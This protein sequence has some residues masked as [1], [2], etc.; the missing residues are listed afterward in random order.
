[1]KQFTPKTSI[2]AIRLAVWFILLA[3]LPLLTLVLFVRH[4]AQIALVDFENQHHYNLAVILAGQYNSDDPQRVFS[5][6]EEHPLSAFI[7]NDD[8]IYLAHTDRQKINQAAADDLPPEVIQTILHQRDG[9]FSEPFIPHSFALAPLPDGDAVLVIAATNTLVKDLL[10][11]LERDSYFQIFITILVTFFGSGLMIWLLIGHP[12]RKLTRA[13]D[14]FSANQLDVRV[15]PDEMVDDLAVLASVFNAMVNRIREL[16]ENLEE[17]VGQR[18]AELTAIKEQLQVQNRQLEQANLDLGNEIIER[19]SAELLVQR[20][21]EYARALSAC[22]QMLLRSSGGSLAANR[23]L[24]HQALQHL[25]EPVGI[26]KIFIYE[27]FVDAKLGP[28]SRCLVDVCAP[29]VYSVFDTP[30]SSNLIIPWS[31]I[32]A[33]S[34]RR[35][36]AGKPVGG[37]TGTIYADTPSFRDYLLKELHI[38]SMQFFPIHFGEYWWG[39]VGFD[40]RVHERVWSEDEILL[41]GTTSEILSNAMQRWQAEDNLREINTRLEQ[42][43]KKRTADLSETIEL[44]QTEIRDRE[45]AQAETQHLLTTLE[46]RIADRTREISTFFDLTILAARSVDLNDAFKQATPRMLEVTRSRV[47][48]LHLLNPEQTSLNLVT[49]QNLPG[50]IIP[51][52]ESVDLPAPFLQWLQTPDAPLITTS[53]TSLTLLPSAFRLDGFE[54]YLGAPVKIGSKVQGLLSCY[55]FTDSGFGLD[56]ISLVV[57]LSEQIGMMLENHRLRKK[58]G[59]LAVLEERQRLARELHDSVAQSV[60]SL[61]LFARSGLEAVE[62]GDMPR[63]SANLTDIQE[64]ARRVLQEMR[65]LLYELRPPQLEESGLTGAIDSRLNQVERRA[66]LQADF[67]TNLGQTTLPH[68]MEMELYWLAIEALNNVIKHARASHVSV[69]LSQNDDQI[70]LNIADNGLGFDLNQKSGGFGLRGMCERVSRLNGKFDVVTA[71]EQGTQILVK[72][73]LTDE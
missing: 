66:G 3:T 19:T 49:H 1:M 9:W 25:I 39:F 41:L 63:L 73:G 21:F 34:W 15:D 28:C 30:D 7:L 29:G 60:F 26:S 24:L 10:L 43:V 27:N 70:I 8:G 31:A 56:E 35:L 6:L 44:L 37:P 45:Q 72:V 65:L 11:Q 52:I 22:S 57:A 59:E 38:L 2:L 33:E 18:T 69:S 53:L 17:R 4:N 48:C 20:Q 71:P 54:S 16:V 51:V 32:P 23:Q 62:D 61:T 55:R 36:E 40:D 5:S 14:R 67:Y 42:Q 58:T 47:V 68:A 46:Q 13:A 50:A 12:V 64:S